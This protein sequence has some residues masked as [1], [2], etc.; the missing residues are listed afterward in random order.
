[1]GTRYHG[2]QIQK[3]ANT[4]QA[5]FQRA[6]QAVL[7]R[8]PDIKCCSRTDAGVHAR[9]FCISF[10][11]GGD[12]APGRLQMALNNNL[13]PDIRATAARFVP[14]DFHARYSATGKRYRYL[15]WNHAVMDPFYVERAAQFVPPIDERALHSVAQVFVGRHDF[16]AFCAKKSDVEDTVRTVSDYSVARSGDL[17]SFS[18]TAD[19]FLYNMARAMAGTLLNAA[20]GKLSREDIETRL[21]TGVRDNLVATAP[22]CGLYLDEV[23]YEIAVD[24]GEC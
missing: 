19:G 17:V 12:L 6:L 18:V 11:D 24:R 5:E 14:T 23:F 13:P 3:N 10:L 4:V 22:A 8:L 20:R 9:M 15:V 21:K 7:G 2:S 1:M 16:S